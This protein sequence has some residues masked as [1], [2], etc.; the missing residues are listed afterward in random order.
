MYLCADCSLGR[1][2]MVCRQ[3]GSVPILNAYVTVCRLKPWQTTDGLQTDS[4]HSNT[5]FLCNCVQTAALADNQCFADSQM[6]V[7]KLNAYVNVCRL[8]LWQKTNV[9][10]TARIRS[11][12]Q[13]L[14]N[15]VQTVALADRRWFVDSQ[16]PFQY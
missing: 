6:S 15:C 1:Q 12:T 2:P 10:Q 8:Q 11:N 14:Y 4:L 3:P 5:E 9:L 7:P 16:C 13:C